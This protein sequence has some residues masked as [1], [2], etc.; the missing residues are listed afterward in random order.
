MLV[1]T[2]FFQMAHAQQNPATLQHLTLQQAD[3][4]FE[5]HNFQLLAERYNLSSAEAQIIQ[6][7]LWDNPNLA[8]AQGAYNPETK[9]VFQLSGPRSENAVAIQELFRLAGKRGWQIRMARTNAQ[10]EANNFYD[11][12][13]TL[14]HSLSSTF[15]DLY[16]QRKDEAMYLQ[17]IESLN[18]T[19][20]AFQTN[21]Q[22]GFIAEKEVIR[23]QA[24]LLSLESDYNDLKNQMV[25]HEADL[26][27]LLG[28]SSG[29]IIPILP[30]QNLIALRPEEVS[31][32]QLLDSAY[33]HRP[34]LR[35][36]EETILLNQE[37]LSYQKALAIPDVTLGASYDK[38]GS[39]I[40]NYN[41]ATL[42]FDLPILNRNQGN[43]KAA[44]AQVKSAE[45]Q[46]QE[47]ELEVSNQLSASYLQALNT[48]SLS[49]SIPINLE[50]TFQRTASKMMAAYTSRTI[51]LLEFIDFFDAYKETTLQINAILDS[52]IQALEN[53]NYECGTSVYRF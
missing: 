36:S 9:Q 39:Y 14:K 3:S 24:L 38:R 40:T 19:I 28:D 42:S 7:K 45:A 17:E 53:L 21:M 20:K 31:L 34:D 41:A 33:T 26:R 29:E 52:K 12:I 6:A 48:D 35:Q 11:L 27:I 13:R 25:Q 32:G 44:R 1:L 43:I 50:A 37:N 46:L 47:H 8:L 49:K 2:C 16:F 15:F 30:V 22:N 51:G 5:L 23:M 4:L 10:L 18:Q